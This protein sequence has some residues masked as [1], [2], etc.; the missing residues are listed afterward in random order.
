MPQK[1][2]L[3]A[4]DEISEAFEKIEELM[5]KYN[6]SFSFES[7]HFLDAQKEDVPYILNIDL[8]KLEQ[9]LNK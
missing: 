4:V 6:F 8:N 7:N 5:N 2:L 9:S 3:D 1:I